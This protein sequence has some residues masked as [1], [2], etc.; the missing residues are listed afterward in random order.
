MHTVFLYF[1]FY[2]MSFQPRFQVG[3][4]RTDVSA[5]T[6]AS[7]LSPWPDSFLWHLLLL[8]FYCLILLSPLLAPAM[9]VGCNGWG[10]HLAL[11]FCPSPGLHSEW[12]VNLIYKSWMDPVLRKHRCIFLQP[13]SEMLVPVVS[14]TFCFLDVNVPVL[15]LAFIKMHYSV[16]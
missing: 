9:E 5:L 11:C 12:P 7:P 15:L 10:M 1:I 14:G 8:S 2:V 13:I 16:V 3:T 6:Q 4:Q